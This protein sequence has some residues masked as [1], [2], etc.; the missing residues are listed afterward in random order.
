MYVKR[1]IIVRAELEVLAT[2]LIA[3]LAGENQRRTLS[4]ELVSA[5]NQNGRV[6]A[7]A[8]S[9]LIDAKFTEVLT[10]ADIMFALCQQNEISVTLEQ[11]ETLVNTSIIRDLEL[12]SWQTT[13][14]ENG[15][16]V[17]LEVD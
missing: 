1:T 8:G 3:A 15:L 14:S 2:S 4:V 17:K 11:C 7:F 16:C 13:L 10:D 5:N 12:E 9:G 6:L